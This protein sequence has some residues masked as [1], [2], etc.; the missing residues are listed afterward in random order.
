MQAVSSI[1]AGSHSGC[2]VASRTAILLCRQ[3]R[4]CGGWDDW[5]HLLNRRPLD[6]R[7]LLLWSHAATH[8]AHGQ[9]YAATAAAMIR[10][11]DTW[12]ELRH[13]QRKDIVETATRLRVNKK[14]KGVPNAILE[15]SEHFLNPLR[16]DASPLSAILL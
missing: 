13:L 11:N 2:G 1:S 14:R 10:S 5:H 16:K 15:V 8:R 9:N 6:A 3:C 4:N 12:K 7:P